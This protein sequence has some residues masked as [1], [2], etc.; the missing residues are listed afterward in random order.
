MFSNIIYFSLSVFQCI[1]FALTL[2][3]IP[4]ISAGSDFSVDTWEVLNTHYDIVRT[5]EYHAFELR[6]LLIL[7]EDVLNSLSGTE[8]KH[9]DVEIV[10]SHDQLLDKE[11]V[12]LDIEWDENQTNGFQV[13]REILCLTGFFHLE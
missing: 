6:I 8:N 5:G 3:C 1:I 10:L 2:F 13:S 11:D 7:V 12:A 9:F 4:L